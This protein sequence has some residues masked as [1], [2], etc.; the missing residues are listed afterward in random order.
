MNAARNPTSFRAVLALRSIVFY[1]GFAALCVWFGATG[2]MLAPLKLAAPNWHYRY[3]ML[4][5]RCLMLW[6]RCACGIRYRVVG[7]DNLPE[8]SCV[9]M[10][11]HQST[12]ET[13]AISTICWPKPVCIV[14]KRELLRIPFFGWGLATMRPLAIDRNRPRSALRKIM[15]LGGQRLS[16]GASVLIFPEGT[17]QPPGAVGRLSS[18]GAALAIANAVCVVPIAHDSGR[19]W[20]AHRLLKYPGTIDVAVGPP[21]DGALG[22]REITRRCETWMRQHAQSRRGAG[23]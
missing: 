13:C 9:L 6:L 4:F 7:K 18:G 14:I 19:R 11:Q 2:V 3:M 16:S 1:C 20:P 12:W 10:C 21:L 17:R 23:P 22:A 15:T 8:S 5:M